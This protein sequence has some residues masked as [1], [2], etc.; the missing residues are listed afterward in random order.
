MKINDFEY[1]VRKFSY[2]SSQ[3]P[4]DLRFAHEV[5]WSRI[6]EYPFAIAEIKNINRH[7]VTLHNAA[8][9]H[10]GIHLVFKSCIDQM[11]LV[12][13]HSDIKQSSYYN[14][15]F[16]DISSQ[17]NEA[18]VD[19]F[20][21]VLNISTLEELSYSHVEAIK[22]HLVQLTFGG[23]FVCTFDVPGLQIESVEKFLDERIV[24]PSNRLNPRN[25]KCPDNILGLPEEY[26]V[27]YLVIERIK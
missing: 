25:S 17:P 23:K 7:Q 3:D 6:Y 11:N 27:G 26:T 14:T 10:S 20:D 1:R 24:Q 9:G 8:W 21:L 18:W 4:Y 15:V 22:N 19:R 13:I 16:W 5:C 12:A 2:F